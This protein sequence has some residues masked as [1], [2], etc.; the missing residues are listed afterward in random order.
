[1]DCHR[2][3]IDWQREECILLRVGLQENKDRMGELLVQQQLV[4]VLILFLL[5]SLC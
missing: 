4:R 5:F 2:E 1:M 3:D